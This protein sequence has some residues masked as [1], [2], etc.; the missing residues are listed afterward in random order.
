[1]KPSRKAILVRLAVDHSYG[2]WNA[3]VD[4]E[5]RRFLYVPIPEKS[6]T[7]F[8]KGCRRSYRDL[9]PT[10]RAFAQTFGLDAVRDLRRQPLGS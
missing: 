1:M 8:H 7:A 10:I 5:S 6:G 9:L 3:P 2:G 4:P